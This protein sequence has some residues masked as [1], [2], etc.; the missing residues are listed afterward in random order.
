[1]DPTGASYGFP[2]DNMDEMIIDAEAEDTE[3]EESSLGDPFEDW[4]TLYGMQHIST[5][6]MEAPGPGGTWGKFYTTYGGGPEGGLVYL[7]AHLNETV[8][9]G[10]YEWNRSWFSLVRLEYAGNQKAAYAR[11]EPGVE[12]L[13]LVPPDYELR[14]EWEEVWFDDVADSDEGDRPEN[15]EEEVEEEVVEE[16]D[17]EEEETFEW[18]LQLN[19]E[20]VQGNWDIGQLTDAEWERVKEYLENYME[21]ALT[22]LNN[23]VFNFMQELRHVGEEDL[24]PEDEDEDRQES[25]STPG[26]LPH[27][28]AVV[29]NTTRQAD[30]VVYDGDDQDIESSDDESHAEFIGHFVA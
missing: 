23:L 16:A 4:S 7:Y 3:G 8:P 18:S 10:L 14:D 13:L 19:R 17:E 12:K 26:D 15:A 25:T 28:V 9:L 29:Q 1:M 20:T 6:S 11:P 2:G 24:D 5:E 30:M 22:G 21:H 27:N